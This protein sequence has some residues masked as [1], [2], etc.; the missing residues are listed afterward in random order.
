[1][2]TDYIFI[3]SVAPRFG[4]YAC[5]GFNLVHNPD[6]ERT[7]NSDLYQISKQ[8]SGVVYEGLDLKKEVCYGHNLPLKPHQMGTRRPFDFNVEGL[9]HYG[10]IPDML[11]D[12]K[13]LDM[14]SEDFEALFSSAED[15]LQMWEKTWQVAGCD[16]SKAGC[17][18]VLTQLDCD[19]ACNGLCPESPNAGAPNVRNR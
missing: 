12:L 8:G 13:N 9:A 18:P 7:N 4:R 5:W 16:L 14:T 15:Y 17:Q 6:E 11:Q 1:M 10:L 19:K 3:P 2:A